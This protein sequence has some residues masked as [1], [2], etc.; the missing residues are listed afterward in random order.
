MPSPAPNNSGIA[1]TAPAAGGRRPG[2]SAA[3]GRLTPGAAPSDRARRPVPQWLL[4]GL[5]TLIGL[6]HAALVAG[7]YHFGSFDDDASYVLTAR[8]LLSGQGLGGHLASGQ[9]VVG[10]Y[11]PG[12]S[13]LIA[14]LVWAWPHSVLPLRLFSLVCF[15]A[16]FPLTWIYLGRHGVGPRTRAA[17]LTVMALGPPVATFA[18]MVMAEAPFLVV[19]LLLLLAVDSWTASEALVGRH[20]AAAVV[21][22]AAL[23]WL[24]QA[25][26][27]LVAGLV[28]WL[29]LAPGS[30][31]RARGVV[32]AAGVGLTLLPVVV[33]R[34]AVG[35]PLAGARYS[36]ELGG[37]Y[38]GGLAGR[39]VHVLP[40]SVWHLLATAIPATIVPYL[41]PLPIAGHWPDLW[42]VLSWHVTL[43]VVVGAALWARRQRDAAVPMVTVYLF[44][45]VLW[46]YVNER[47]AIL[48]LPLL[49]GW[50]V[51]GAVWAARWAGRWAAH[52]RPRPDRR[53]VA[54]LATFAVAAVVAGP[55]IAQAPRDYLYGWG[56][57]SSRP[58]GSRYVAILSRLGAPS[59]VVETDYQ[60]TI[61]LLTGHAT[62]WSAFLATST[63]L[64]WLPGVQADLASDRAGYLVLGDVNKPGLVDSSCLAGLMPTYTGAVPLL[65][66]AR[67]SATVYELV[68]PGTGH[69]Q[70]TDVLAS[71]TPAL[72]TSG[73]TT[74]TARW[75][76]PRPEPVSQVSIGQAAALVGPTTDVRVQV[77]RPDG[78]WVTLASAT[79]AVGDGAAA[80]APF[81]LAT[82]ARPLLAVALR[83]IVT[84]P[85][86]AAG[87]QVTDAAMIGPGPAGPGPAATTK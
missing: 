6:V 18:T 17:A 58:M 62:N 56:Q 54:G 50:Y 40:S 10:L 5:P 68:G 44:E 63:G 51:T 34:S 66:T 12:Y 60:S 2:G 37:Y 33:A 84:G 16:L 31:R 24:K 64:C 53:V 14:P 36:E 79:S 85:G 80:R 29:L 81:L 76:L 4:L 38:S 3:A 87:A 49:V 32:M 43:L 69:P 65:H 42:K 7:R 39:L 57:S 28:L 27:G 23:I 30:S 74:A 52:H 45:C 71:A 1:T 25:G 8:A 86:A 9:T 46:P 19:L 72:L 77:E 47:R 75:L 15:G 20:G 22:A 13:A 41:E 82:P 67:D 21:W 83:V 48:V 55:L 11:P 73:G 26:L 70:L 59:D 35:V 78:R 61:A